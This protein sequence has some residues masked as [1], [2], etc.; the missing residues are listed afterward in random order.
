MVVVRT[1]FIR[2]VISKKPTFH[3][4]SVPDGTKGLVEWVVLLAV[5]AVASAVVAVD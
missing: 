4:P 2:S 1:Q 3:P 5:E